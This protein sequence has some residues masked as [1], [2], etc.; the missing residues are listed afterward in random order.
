M[1]RSKKYIFFIVLFLVCFSFTVKGEEINV[2]FEHISRE[3]GLP[4]VSINVIAQ[5]EMG[6]LWFGT[7]G[8]LTR[9]D[10][11]EFYTFKTEVDHPNSLADNSVWAIL[12]DDEGTMWVGTNG[13]LSKFDRKTEKF[14]NYRF[15]PKDQTTLSDNNVR[16]LRL[17]SQGTLWV[18]TRNGG[19]N[20][21]NPRNK[22]LV[23]QRYKHE[24]NNE[25]SI[26][27]NYIQD[28]YEDDQGRLFIATNGGGLDLLDLKNKEKGFN[29]F[30]FDSQNSKSISSNNV[31]SIFKSRK[32]GLFIG[33]DKGLN[34]LDNEGTGFEHFKYELRNETVLFD[35]SVSCIAEDTKGNLWIGSNGGG[36]TKMDAKDHFQNFTS[37]TDGNSISG[38]D[39][40]SLYVDRQGLLWIGT[41]G[42]GL[43]KMDYGN[44]GFSILKHK[45]DNSKSLSS[46]IILSILEDGDGV[47]WAGTWNGGVNR[48]KDRKNVDLKLINDPE[49]EISIGGN[50]VWSMEE[51]RRGD[52]WIGTWKNGLSRIKNKERSKDDPEILRYNHDVNDP[53]SLGSDSIMSIC[54]DSRGIL[55]IGTWGGGLN[56]LDPD[57]LKKGNIN[58]KKY[59]HD[60]KNDKSLGDNF[61]KTIM[62]DDS[63]NVWIGTWGGGISML[64]SENIISGK[65]KFKR[66][67]RSWADSNTLSHN[68]VTA[69]YQDE[70]GIFWICTYGGGLN[71]FDY[72][73]GQF[74]CYT[75]K[76][77]LSNPELYG[78]VQDD[79]GFLWIS[80]N[81]GINK[82]NPKN[83]S[84]EA[85]DARD[86]LQGD[87]FNQGAFL[88]GDNGELYFGGIGG[89]SI[90]SP[91]EIVKSKFVPPVYFTELRVMH[92]VIKPTQS[93][94]LTKPIYDTDEITLSYKDATFGVRFAALNYRQSDKNNYAYMLEGFDKNWIYTD[95]P[96]Q[97]VQYTNLDPGT[98]VFLV[99]A[100][101][102]DGIWNTQGSSLKITILPPWW[103]LWWV[104]GMGILLF[105]GILFGVHFTRIRLLK[106]QQKYL[107]REVASRTEQITIQKKEIIKKNEELSEKNILLKKQAEE[108]H[109]L[110]E[111]LLDQNQ[112]LE[113]AQKASELAFLQAQI[114][115]HFLYNALNTISFLCTEEPEK[116]SQLIDYLSIFLR[117]SFNIEEG[118]SFIS[119]SKE[120]KLVKAYLEI[121]KARFKDKI[122]IIYKIDENI[123]GYIPHLILQPIVE[124]AIKHG[125]LQ[126]YGGGNVWIKIEDQQD[127][128]Y[129]EVKDDGVGMSEEKYQN[130]LK[131]TVY[132]EGVGVKNI[133]RRLIEFYGKGL[134]IES[135]E[136]VGTIVKF[137]ILKRK[138]R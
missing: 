73:T 25:N 87:E 67:Q 84:F 56:R 5:D 92:K 125:I 19:L 78:V 26:S 111:Q 94:I 53:K 103:K 107:E 108:L 89:L 49:S 70:E 15:D 138:K 133:N 85:Y 102:D 61:I 75:Q 77:G 1:Q 137:S 95:Y 12:F 44:R 22:K 130:L 32:K 81:R 101:N 109:I 55:W 80:T 135:A 54:E 119:I 52:I 40:R 58:F 41:Y 124:N 11:Y 3:Q 36:L 20:S 86:G 90:I 126:K 129:F 127:C 38:S 115:P 13:G 132:K 88:K 122:N 39:V 47:L 106:K 65:N 4:Q 30:Q 10:G 123:D 62:E 6:F 97:S 31:L 42:S 118:N 82:F 91:K 105:G 9:F 46:D 7:Q 74:K 57:D 27:S 93:E 76:D 8:G 121:E 63:G 64:S 60:P 99:K 114:K 113:V 18:G 116:A 35:K 51:D 16:S 104:R 71:R 14:T 37:K 66:Y 2:Y 29:H 23:F 96:I 48:L 45:K 136:N 120:V 128:V 83:E 17:D 100:S 68:D 50:T 24:K 59:L 28:L 69:I 112:L 72:K 34:R 43:N 98:Y 33:T 117:N 134:A 131:G 21:C 110:A 79:N